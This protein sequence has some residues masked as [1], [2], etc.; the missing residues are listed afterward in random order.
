MIRKARKT[1][2][3]IENGNILVCGARLYTTKFPHNFGVCYVYMCV[4]IK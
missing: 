1:H 3:W 2:V 4:C